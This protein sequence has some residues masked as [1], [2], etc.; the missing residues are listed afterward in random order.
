MSE[1]ESEQRSATGAAGK[2]ETASAGELASRVAEFV[3]E[4]AGFRGGE[5]PLW[6][7]LGRGGSGSNRGS[8]LIPT[9]AWCIVLSLSAIAL[10]RYFWHDDRWPLVLLNAFTLYLYLP[11]Y[12][13]LAYAAL[14]RRRALAGL[15]MAMIACHLVLIWPDLRPAQSP[16]TATRQSRAVR[17]YFANVHAS[18]QN[19]EGILSEARSFDPDVI[20]L[21]EMQRW[22]WRQM[23]SRNPLPDYPYGTNLARR[24]AGDLGVF[25]RLPVRSMKQIAAGGRF[26]LQADIAVDDDALRL[27]AMHSP[28]PTPDTFDEYQQFWDLVGRAVAADQGPVVVIGDFNATQYSRVHRQLQEGGLRSAHEERGRGLA[29]SWPNPFP[30]IRIDQAFVSPEVQC[31]AVQMGEAPGSDHKSLI[32]E[33]VVQ[34]PGDRPQADHSGA[35]GSKVD[36][37]GD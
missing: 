1:T 15:S 12:A 3:D 28:R 17:I 21:A 20:V 6:S 24:N 37:P 36:P 13:I 33:V 8:V 29:L 26:A 7:R 2:K 9:L 30:L 4:D 27:F 16:A 18:N 34:P 23:I 14:T 11:A 19:L 35:E 32:V 22:W 5:L 10:L 25:S 31:L